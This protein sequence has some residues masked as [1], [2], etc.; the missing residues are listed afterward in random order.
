MFSNYWLPWHCADNPYECCWWGKPQ[1]WADTGHNSKDLIC[2]PQAAE[3][4]QDLAGTRVLCSSSSWSWHSQCLFKEREI[5]ANINQCSRN[6]NAASLTGMRV[7]FHDLFLYQRPRLYLT[8][9]LYACWDWGRQMSRH[10]SQKNCWIQ[11]WSWWWAAGHKS[12]FVSIYRYIAFP[13]EQVMT[14]LCRH[15]HKGITLWE[16]DFCP[17]NDVGKGH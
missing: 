9:P 5:L 10:S 15:G 14:A 8:C 7:M 6:C 11:S 4:Q 13:M 17:C 16:T 2:H 1:P 3:S 12:N